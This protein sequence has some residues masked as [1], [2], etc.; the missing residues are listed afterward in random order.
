MQ[1]EGLANFP[2]RPGNNYCTASRSRTGWRIF[3]AFRT[4]AAK[5]STAGTTLRWPKA[6]IGRRGGWEELDAR[7]VNAVLETVGLS[8]HAPEPNINRSAFKPR[9][10]PDPMQS[11]V[12]F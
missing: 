11:S 10:Q 5:A 8:A 6:E 3:C 7:Q 2:N 9:R 12:D 1:Y 4:A